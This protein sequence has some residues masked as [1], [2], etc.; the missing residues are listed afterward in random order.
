MDDTTL[1]GTKTGYIKE[2]KEIIFGSVHN[3][4]NIGDGFIDGNENILFNPTVANI[5]GHIVTIPGGEN[6][7]RYT[8]PMGKYIQT[9]DNTI[10]VKIDWNYGF[11][12][13]DDSETLDWN[14]I[15][16]NDSDYWNTTFG[17]WT[18]SEQS[19]IYSSTYYK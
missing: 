19:F 8:K 14:I 2:N 16:Y 6:S 1:I 15:N 9:G 12:Y 7:I 13:L 5:N 10:V 11:E 4:I 17:L 3:D 18:R